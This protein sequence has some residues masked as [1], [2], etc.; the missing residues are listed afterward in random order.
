MLSQQ[1]F[2]SALNDCLTMAPLTMQAA[3]LACMNV[4]DWTAPLSMPA[5]RLKNLDDDSPLLMPVQSNCGKTTNMLKAEIWADDAQR[6]KVVAIGVQPGDSPTMKFLSTTWGAMG[7]QT[8]KATPLNWNKAQMEG[9][10]I[11]LELDNSTT[12]DS[13]CETGGIYNTCW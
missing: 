13:F 11:C 3:A 5:P 8:V 9:G 10:K 4:V 2:D 1:L 12:L 7:E 6:R